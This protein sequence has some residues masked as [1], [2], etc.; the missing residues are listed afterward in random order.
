[1]YPKMQEHPKDVLAIK[2]NRAVIKSR[3]A[4]QEETSVTKTVIVLGVVSA[5]ILVQLLSDLF[6]AIGVIGKFFG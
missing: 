1:M 2:A 6:A 3:P 5:I 4:A